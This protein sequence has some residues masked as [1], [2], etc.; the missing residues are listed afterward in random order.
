MGGTPEE[1]EQKAGGRFRSAHNEPGYSRLFSERDGRPPTEKG[2]KM[3]RTSGGKTKRPRGEEDKRTMTRGG[4]EKKPG[5]IYRR[6]TTRGGPRRS[7]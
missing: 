3:G 4:G 2:E 1:E 7:N 6:E 5:S